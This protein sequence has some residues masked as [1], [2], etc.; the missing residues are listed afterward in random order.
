M[1]QAVSRRPFTAE[2]RVLARVSPYGICDQSGTRTGFA[3]KCFSFALSISFHR[4]SL[5][6]YITWGIN[7]RPVWWLQFRDI[8]ALY[9]HDQQQHGNALK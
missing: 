6:S 7:N 9:R 3:L 2:I 5:Y 8:V 4:G 1:V